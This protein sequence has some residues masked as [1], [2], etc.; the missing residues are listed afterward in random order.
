MRTLAIWRDRFVAALPEVRALGFD[1][2]FIR[3]WM[4]YLAIS[5]AAFAERTLADHHL[6][7]VR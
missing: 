4:L 1:T 2:P 7:F 3:T 5:E 6:R